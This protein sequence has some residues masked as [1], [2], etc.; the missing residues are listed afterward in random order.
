VY[1]EEAVE[2]MLGVLRDVE[3]GVD[4]AG[5]DIDVEVVLVHKCCSVIGGLHSALFGLL[6]A[7][8][9]GDVEGIGL[10]QQ[11]DE[12]AVG[13]VRDTGTGEH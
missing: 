4:G 7:R 1:H 5:T 10:R 9:T 2:E 11:S 3:V 12:V 13:V 6:G 8:H